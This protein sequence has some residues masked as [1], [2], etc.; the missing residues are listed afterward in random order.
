MAE[1]LRP[2]GRLLRFLD[3]AEPTGRRRRLHSSPGSRCTRAARASLWDE[4]GPP[5]TA[6][7]AAPA[8]TRDC[9]PRGG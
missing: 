6:G 3:P 9:G 1:T 4:D 8:R 7:E 5:R 2:R